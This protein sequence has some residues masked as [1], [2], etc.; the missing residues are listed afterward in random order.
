MGGGIL[1]P[2]LADSLAPEQFHLLTN[3]PFL[4]GCVRTIT[5]L[6]HLHVR[7]WRPERLWGLCLLLLASHPPYTCMCT[8]TPSQH[9]PLTYECAH[10]CIHNPSQHTPLI[11]ACAHTCIHNP[12]QHGDWGAHACIHISSQH[13]GQGRAT[14]FGGLCL[15]PIREQ[16]RNALKMSDSPLIRVGKLELAG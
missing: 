5:G 14:G 16:A 9:T 12:S 2:P 7:L 6:Y 13:G 8:H 1:L 10:T 11:Y 4:G 15:P 3:L